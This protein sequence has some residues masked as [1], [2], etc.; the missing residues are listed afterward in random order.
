LLPR[1]ALKLATAF[2]L[3]AP[4]WW[5]A[6]GQ[7]ALSLLAGLLAGGLIAALAYRSERELIGKVRENLKRPEKNTD[8]DASAGEASDG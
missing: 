3:V 5:V 6:R 1:A 4:I 8:K 2:A 7:G